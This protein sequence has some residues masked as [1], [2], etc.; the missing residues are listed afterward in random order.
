MRGA[1]AVM[2][3]LAAHGVKDIFALSGN[4]IMPL[5]DA[6]IDAGVRLYHTR[7]EAAAVYMAE[8]YA[9]MI[10]GV[11]VALVTAGAGL[12]NA[13]GPLLT[14]RASDTPVLL[15]SGDSPV[16]RD[17]QGAFQEMDQVGLTQSLTKWSVR[18]TSA[19]DLS[20]TIDRA[21][22]VALSGRPGPVHVSLP[23]DVLLAATEIGSLAQT[24][25]TVAPEVGALRQWIDAADRPVLVLGPALNATR[26][27]GLA[28]KLEQATGAPVIVMESPRG[29]KDPSLGAIAGV[30]AEADR[31]VLL[32]KPLDFTL[33]FGAAAPEAG[34]AV[35]NADPGEVARARLNAGDRVALSIEADAVA[36]ADTLCNG[37]AAKQARDW[38][39]RVQDACARREVTRQ[40][41]N[42]LDSSRLCS[43]VH[44][45]LDEVGTPVLVCDGGEFGQWAQA[46]VSAPRR[47]IN[48]VSGAIGGGLCY[49][50]AARA[51]DPSATVVALMGDGTVGFHF[52]EFETAVREN[53]PF[54]A[55]IGNDQR[56]NAEHQIQLRD[57]GAD[58]THGCD[59]SGARY[60]EAVTALGGFGVLVT[61]AKDLPEALRRAIASGKPACVNVMIE[62]QPAPV[63]T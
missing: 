29:M 13:L 21:V 10:G 16:A 5:F 52:A 26:R 15:L 44:K 9:Q 39:G 1:D 34:W 33:G 4:Q 40:V 17:G 7:H 6:S 3:T 27:P 60:D 36:V 48:G 50:M 43:E 56:W 41:E 38:T 30:F 57:F 32:G 18:V 22:R 58:R 53:L 35:V 51:A 61:D 55:V 37:S 24:S 45:A 62:G 11:G 54:V 19:E 14:A 59:L 12:G 46:S 8:G 20:A 25:D 49:A 63:V 42:L 2:R 47:V 23:A 31:V 28:E